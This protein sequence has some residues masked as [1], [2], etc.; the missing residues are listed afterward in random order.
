MVIKN[1][2][3][4]SDR[5]EAQRFRYGLGVLDRIFKIQIGKQIRLASAREGLTCCIHRCG[6]AAT[7]YPCTLLL[8]INTYSSIHDYVDHGS[9]V[10]GMVNRYSHV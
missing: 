8:A 1:F 5:P 6:H 7:T 2:F 9:Q 10:T 3:L 4:Y